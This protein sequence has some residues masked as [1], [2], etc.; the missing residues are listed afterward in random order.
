[1][2]DDS[3]SEDKGRAFVLCGYVASTQ[4][5]DSFAED[6]RSI[7]DTD[8]KIEYFKMREANSR[9]GQ[10]WGIPPELRDKKVIELVEFTKRHV[11]LGITSCVFWEDFK[12][13]SGEA[14]DVPL[15]P[16]DLLFQGTMA[17]VVDH[18]IKRL[19]NEQIDF[20][21]DEQGKWGTRAASAF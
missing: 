9:R 7:L 5:W 19:I 21:F 6:W 8:P 14:A 12:E 18:L 1:F 3:G 2:I 10:F 17:V 11:L 13:V 16:Y 4:Q 15:H 20:V